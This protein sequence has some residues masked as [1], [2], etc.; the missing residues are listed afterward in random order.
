[1]GALLRLHVCVAERVLRPIEGW[2]GGV[3]GREHLEGAGELVC[4]PNVILIT[5]CHVVDILRHG[6]NCL[7]E[8]PNHSQ[9][10][11]PQERDDPAFLVSFQHL[12]R[13]VARAIVAN[14]DRQIRIGCNILGQNA[15]QLLFHVRR[16]V[17]RGHHNGDAPPSL[18][19]AHKTLQS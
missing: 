17:I 15:V 14:I 1:M 13:I 11:A 19:F 8:G 16:P 3:V 4:V 2:H 18:R 10:L 7:A 6:S 5:Q 12:K 9:I